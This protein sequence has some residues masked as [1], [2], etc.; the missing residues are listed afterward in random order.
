MAVFVATDYKITLNGT[1]LSTSLVQ[2]ELSLEADDVETT[3]FGSTWR[4][5]IGGLKA[6]SLNLQ[7]NQ[8]FAAA[9]VDATLFPLFGTIGTVVIS[10]TSS[11][12]SATNP[13]YTAT[14]LCNSYSPFASSV[15]DLATVS[16][17]WPTTG[18]VSRGTA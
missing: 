11:A 8:D 2:A 9:A 18:T 3:A 10:P 6:G 7:F 16:V 17:T 13:S 4:S 14:V 1:N 12:V 15:G 5:R